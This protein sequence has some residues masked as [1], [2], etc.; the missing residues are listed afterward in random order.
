MKSRDQ[1]GFLDA[2]RIRTE[3]AASAPLVSLTSSQRRASSTAVR[4]LEVKTI[5]QCL[6]PK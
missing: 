6:R 5:A 4:L 3:L 1:R 2:S